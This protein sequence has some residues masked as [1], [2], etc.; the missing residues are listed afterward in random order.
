L[1]NNG[2]FVIEAEVQPPGCYLPTSTSIGCNGDLL[3]SYAGEFS[4]LLPANISAI[5]HINLKFISVAGNEVLDEIQTCIFTHDYMSDNLFDYWNG[6]SLP[7]VDLPFA[8]KKLM[9]EFYWH[10]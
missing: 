8:K 4:F 2:C 10:L 3:P 1:Q 6:H 5:F 9:G 7:A